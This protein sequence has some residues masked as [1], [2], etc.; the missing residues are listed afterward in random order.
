VNLTFEVLVVIMKITVVWVVT[1]C[2]LV[3]VYRHV[4]S[5]FYPMHPVVH[6]FGRLGSVNTTK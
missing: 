4:R 3:D 1:P 2:G 5:Y 6:L